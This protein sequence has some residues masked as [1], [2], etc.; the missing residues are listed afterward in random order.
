MS[1]KAADTVSQILLSR[2][3]F[4]TT[5]FDASITLGNGVSR[6]DLLV[7]SLIDSINNKENFTLGDVFINLTHH[8]KASSAFAPANKKNIPDLK[9]CK[10][11]GD[12]KF[13]KKSSE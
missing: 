12:Y 5:C 8:L 1:S 4:D 3:N 11:N 9:N 7:K 13:I 2:W 6:W 10:I